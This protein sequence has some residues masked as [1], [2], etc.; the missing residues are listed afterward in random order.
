MSFRPPRRLITVLRRGESSEPCRTKSTNRRIVA[1]PH[2]RGDG[3][4]EPYAPPLR[5]W[6]R[7][8]L[9]IRPGLYPRSNGT[10]IVKFEPKGPVLWPELR[11]ANAGIVTTVTEHGIGVSLS[12]LRS[13][14]LDWPVSSEHTIGLFAGSTA[15]AVVTVMAL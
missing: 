2:T 15:K 11:A 9:V 14:S 5:R 12:D 1:L 8:P 7:L 6:C 4:T 3:T 13:E 10:E